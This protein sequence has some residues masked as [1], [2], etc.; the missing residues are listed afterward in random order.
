MD[1]EEK[2]LIALVLIVIG[3]V[4][5]YFVAIGKSQNSIDVE[6]K[7]KYGNE[8][9]GRSSNYQPNYCVNGNGDIKAL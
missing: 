7:A 4:A 9:N 2:T 8:W 6:C 1:F 3:V 5:L